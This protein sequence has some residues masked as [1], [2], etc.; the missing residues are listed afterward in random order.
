MSERS[1]V[2]E[3]DAVRDTAPAYQVTPSESVLVDVPRGYKRTEMGVIPTCWHVRRLDSVG[4]EPAVK[5]GPFG[6]SITKA[7]YSASGYKVYG[8][9]QVIRGDH[10]FG[11]YFIPEAKF[12]QLRS[13]SVRPQDVLISLVGTAGK[14]LL[15]PDDAVPGVINPRLVRVRLTDEQVDPLFFKYLFESSQ[16]QDV[17]IGNAQGGTMDVLNASILRSLPMSVPP[18]SEQRAIA[19]ATVLSDMDTEIETLEHRRDKARQI[20]QGMMQ[21]LLIGRVRLV[22]HTAGESQEAVRP[23]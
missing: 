16:V 15:V 18:L 17:L 6:S 7:S 22:G 23:T 2:L 3:Q 8:Q 5:A 14:A 21:Q 10:S 4:I 19:T 20:K 11:D 9:E 12:Q 13:C 1:Q